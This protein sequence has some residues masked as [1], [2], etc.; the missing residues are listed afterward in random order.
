MSE[1]EQQQRPA[2]QEL[3]SEEQTMMA[4]LQGNPGETAEQVPLTREALSWITSLVSGQPTQ[5]QQEQGQTTVAPLPA[6]VAP[7]QPQAAHEEGEE[8]SESET[9]EVAGDVAEVGS[10]MPPVEA[11][12]A[13]AVQTHVAGT[14]F[15]Q[16]PGDATDIQI[17]DVQQGSLGDCYFLAILA[18]I[19]RTRPDYIRNMVRDNEDGTYTVTFQ[20]AT[21]W[22]GSMGILTDQEVIVDNQFWTDAGGTPTYAKSRDTGTSG[23]ELW[24]MLIEKA[25]AKLKGG[26][27]NIAGGTLTGDPWE[28]VTGEGS[29]S[30]ALSGLEDSE[31]EEQTNEHFAE[32]NLPVVFWSKSDATLNDIN[33]PN[34]VVPDHEYAL[35]GYSGGSY[36]LYNPW[37]RR[38]LNGKDTAFVKEHFQT[39]RFLSID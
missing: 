20:T 15:V 21:G 5:S 8:V 14:P 1:S 34:G 30:V 10:H 22:L 25:Y 32:D 38:H 3:D 17:D 29:G 7:A 6:K 26:Y 39:A 19:A 13:G 31:L 36:D 18:A 11:N 33:D 9:E 35:N 12:D 16:G 2:N 28:T 4:E 37:G 23:P 27:G 24:V